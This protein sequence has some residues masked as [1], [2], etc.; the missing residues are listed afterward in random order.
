M[1]F[2]SLVLNNLK[3]Y[4]VLAIVGVFVSFF[5]VVGILNYFQKV[6]LEGF[7]TLS[8]S[9]NVEKFG[10]HKNHVTSHKTE[11]FDCGGNHNKNIQQ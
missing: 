6:T 5:V 7:V 11:N 8:Q 9:Q 4:K 3:K 10:G 2:E 1:S